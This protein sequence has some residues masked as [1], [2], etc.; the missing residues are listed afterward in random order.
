MKDTIPGND[1]TE[2]ISYPRRSLLIGVS[3]A[4]T[5]DLGHVHHG[6]LLAKKGSGRPRLGI[7]APG[8]IGNAG[9]YPNGTD[10]SAVLERPAQN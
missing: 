9:S 8:L 3:P 4:V 7:G 5:D 10:L 6:L 1:L 2:A